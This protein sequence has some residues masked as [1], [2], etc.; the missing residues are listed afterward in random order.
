MLSTT[1]ESYHPRRTLESTA[2][3]CPP[4]RRN[5]SVSSALL[6]P[7]VLVFAFT[8][9]L[10][11][12]VLAAIVAGIA[13]G[14]FLATWNAIIADRTTTEQRN[15]AFALSFILGNVAGGIGFALPI[16]FPVLEAWTGPITTR[17]TSR[18]SW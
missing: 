14:G 2:S 7:T 11:W 8:T 4:I 13:E 17:S 6:P 3:L 12:L 9:E 10:Q 16:I 15:A 1:E 18:S 5:L